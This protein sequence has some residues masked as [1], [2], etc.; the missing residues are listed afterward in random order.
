MT[1]AF[2]RRG[3][4]SAV[5]DAVDLNLPTALDVLLAESSVIGAARQLG[6]RASAMSRTLERLR[7]A[8]GDPLLGRGGGRI[9]SNASRCGIARPCKRYGIRDWTPTLHS[10]GKGKR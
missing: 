5:M 9:G 4:Y 6:L 2:D 1:L 10:A 7:R 8:T 3:S